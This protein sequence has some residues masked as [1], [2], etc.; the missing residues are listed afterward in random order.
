MP[1]AGAP[2]GLV[3]REVQ[4]DGRGI[5]RAPTR[6]YAR[7]A[8]C[9]EAEEAHG[10]ALKLAPTLGDDLCVK[11]GNLACRRGDMA[12]A[13]QQWEAV[14]RLN[15]GHALARANLAGAGVAR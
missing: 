1:D 7:A 14:L 15:P 5:D 8:G 12:Q 13:A 10:R 4:R 11:L 3:V 9:I 2:T 6:R